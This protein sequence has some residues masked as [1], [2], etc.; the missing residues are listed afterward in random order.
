MT[1]AEQ[2]AE[3]LDVL[4]KLES[5]RVALDEAISAQRRMLAATAVTTP[6]LREPERPEWL[7]VARAAQALAISKAAARQ[8]AQRG[9][10][11]G[12]GRKVGGRLQLFVPRQR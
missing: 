8:R 11:S 12:R 6:V 5:I 3:Q 1:P 7:P 4:E 10:S 9:L 2:R